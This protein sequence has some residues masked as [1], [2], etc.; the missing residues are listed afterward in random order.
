MHAQSVYQR[1]D[2][3]QRAIGGDVLCPA[4]GN[5]RCYFSALPFPSGGSDDPEYQGNLTR[6]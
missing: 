6:F 4:S 2:E 5:G 1:K 3:D